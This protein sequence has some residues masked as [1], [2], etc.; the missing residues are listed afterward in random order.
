MENTKA[1][2]LYSGG[3]DS[4]LVAHMLREFG[5]DVLLATANAGIVEGAKTAQEAAK[6]LG[7]PHEIF[8]IPAEIMEKAAD[9]AQKDGFPLNAINYA[10]HE[11]VEAACEKY[12]G[13][14]KVFADGCRRDDRTPKL[15][16]PEMQSIEDRHGIEFNAPLAGISYKTINYLTEKIF[17]TKAIKAGSIPTSEYETEIREVLRKRGAGP[18]AIF[19]EDH[20]HSI[21]TGYKNG[22]EKNTR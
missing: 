22:R 11:A 15:T 14:H 4:S 6:T 16:F 18:E 2:V 7:F 8:K 21:V 20:Y 9:M 10:H 1:L 13:E 3:K 19:P 12:K 5:Y 17:K